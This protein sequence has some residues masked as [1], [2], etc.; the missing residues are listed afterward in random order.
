[1]SGSKSGTTI[2]SKLTEGEQSEASKTELRLIRTYLCAI[3]VSWDLPTR[4]VTSQAIWFDSM[5]SSCIQEPIYPTANP[6]S[7]CPLL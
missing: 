4:N 7:M 1:M 2:P 3:I 6:S 5:Y